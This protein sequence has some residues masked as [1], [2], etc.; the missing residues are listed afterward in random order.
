MHQ[1]ID[2][3][4]GNVPQEVIESNHFLDLLSERDSKE[5]AEHEDELDQMKIRLDIDDFN[6]STN[7]L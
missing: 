4:E 5:E 6:P 2:E 7:R 1:S 3:E